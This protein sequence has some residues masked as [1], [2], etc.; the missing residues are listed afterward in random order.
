MEAVVSDGDFWLDAVRKCG[1]NSATAGFADLEEL[2]ASG[3]LSSRDLRSLHGA[4]RSI[5]QRA[6]D[7]AAEQDARAKRPWEYK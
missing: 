6:W 1:S 2:I 4:L 5:A 7:G 3:K